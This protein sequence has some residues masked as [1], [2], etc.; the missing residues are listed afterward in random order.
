MGTNFYYKKS[1]KHIGKRSAAGLYC[2]DC[3]ITLCMEGQRGIHQGNSKWHEAC[4]ECGAKP[5]TESLSES[6]SGRELG[7]NTGPPR[8]KTGVATCASFTWA[9]PKEEV[10]QR[11]SSVKIVDEYGRVLSKKEFL[12]VLEECPVEFTHSVAQRFS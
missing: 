1:K 5:V 11:R 3:G 9:V 6:S 4:P 2:W 8:A 10:F 7:F 12:G